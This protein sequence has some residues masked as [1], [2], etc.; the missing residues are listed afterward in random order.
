M[1]PEDALVGALHL[2]FPGKPQEHIEELMVCAKTIAPGDDGNIN[3]IQLMSKVGVP[4]LHTH[5]HMYARTHT[6]S[7]MHTHTHIIML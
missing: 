3:F 6:H 2:L 7:H 1:V 4:L 5:T